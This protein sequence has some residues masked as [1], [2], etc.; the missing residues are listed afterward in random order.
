M[1][2]LSH[3]PS[4][5]ISREPWRPTLFPGKRLTVYNLLITVCEINN[6]GRQRK[7]NGYEHASYT[8]M[9]SASYKPSLSPEPCMRLCPAGA[10]SALW[11]AWPSALACGASPGPTR[12]PRGCQ[13]LGQAAERQEG[14]PVRPAFSAQLGEADRRA[15]EPRV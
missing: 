10:P 4:C 9:I 14:P 13:V 2:D 12:S 15:D 7:N 8:F 1:R 3:C 11:A 5:Y 6:N